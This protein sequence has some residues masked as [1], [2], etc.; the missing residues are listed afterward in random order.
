MAV[1]RLFQTHAEYPHSRV[2]INRR[3][4]PAAEAAEGLDSQRVYPHG[5][6]AT[7]STYHTARGLTGGVSRALA[8][9]TQRS[10]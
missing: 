5:L 10:E 3:V 6:C 8:L 1:E 9:A 2:S 7:A 4:D